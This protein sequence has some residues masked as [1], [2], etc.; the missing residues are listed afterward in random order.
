MA[1]RTDPSDPSGFNI[2]LLLK[3]ARTY[4]AFGEQLQPLSARFHETLAQEGDWNAAL[5][6]Y[7]DA[8]KTALAQ[9]TDDPGSHPELAHLWTATLDGWQQAI[10]SLGFPVSITPQTGTNPD[11]WQAYQRTQTQY[12]GLLQRAAKEALDLMEQR[13]TTQ[14][15]AGATVDHLRD[16]YNLWVECNEETYGR[17]LRSTEYS[18]FS[19][20]LLNTLLR[21]YSAGET[22]P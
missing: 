22:Q 9:A 10:A 20:Y 21:C 12:L 3:S 1:E 4:L 11:A 8:I 2:E 5:G 17:M 19:G 16:L 6:Q 15:A 18:E 14:V 13:L 7:F